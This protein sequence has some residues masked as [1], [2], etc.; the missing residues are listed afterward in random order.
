MLSTIVYGHSKYLFAY[1]IIV[2][3]LKEMKELWSHTHS[4]WLVDNQYCYVLKVECPIE[5]Q[6]MTSQ[7]LC[8]HFCGAKWLLENDSCKRDP[9]FAG[10]LSIG[11]YKQPLRKVLV[12]CLYFFL[13]IRQ[14]LSIVNWCHGGDDWATQSPSSPLWTTLM[15]INSQRTLNCPDK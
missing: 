6:L 10:Y 2:Y 11:D 8:N 9:F 7:V 13:E 12:N 4:F 15:P 1:L 3:S 5:W 14:S